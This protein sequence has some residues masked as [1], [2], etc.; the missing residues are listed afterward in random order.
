MLGEVQ[1]MWRS[2]KVLMWTVS[3]KQPLPARRQ[4][5]G[6]PPQ[7]LPAIQAPPAEALDTTEQRG[8]IFSM[9]C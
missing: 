5:R 9:P 7:W 1:G 8:A 6:K 4:T 3:A 2:S